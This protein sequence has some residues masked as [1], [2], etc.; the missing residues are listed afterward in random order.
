MFIQGRRCLGILRKAKPL[1]AMPGW[2]R[3][4]RGRGISCSCLVLVQEHGGGCAAL[5]SYLRGSGFGH[6]DSV[7]GKRY[8]RTPRTC[9]LHAGWCRMM[10]PP[11]SHIPTPCCAAGAR[12]IPLWPLAFSQF[13]PA[14]CLAVVPTLLLTPEPAH[15]MLTLAPWHPAAL[16]VCSSLTGNSEFTASANNLSQVH[17]DM[18]S[19]Q[20]FSL[21]NHATSW[22]T[23]H[24]LF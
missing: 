7:H 10:C 23:F 20:L 12:T 24:L 1:P 3:R 13:P 8:T 6:R 22:L 9:P 16:H 17:R 19:M 4:Q 15:L 18:D 5:R 2:S 21:G 11:S 14:Q